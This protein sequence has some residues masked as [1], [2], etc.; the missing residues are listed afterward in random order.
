[1]V[2]KDNFP[3]AIAG[4]V[5]GDYRMDGKDVLICCANDGEGV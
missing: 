3:N 2:F 1:M 5:A 4:I